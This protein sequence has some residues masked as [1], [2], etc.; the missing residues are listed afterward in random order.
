MSHRKFAMETHL[1]F[2]VGQ[3]TQIEVPCRVEFTYTPGSPGTPPAYSHGGLPADP[4]ECE[5]GH[6]MVQ[7]EP[8]IQLSLDACMVARLQNDSE[9]INQLCDYA[10]EA[11]AD[12]K[13]EAMERRAEARRDE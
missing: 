9:L 12:E 4:P 2:E 5:I 3:S 7:W 1:L 10:A 6:I 11:M 13:A 8:N